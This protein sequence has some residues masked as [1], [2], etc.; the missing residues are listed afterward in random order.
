MKKIAVLSLQ[1]KF[2]Q[3]EANQTVGAAG[4]GPNAMKIFQNR[5]NVTSRLT[6]EGKNM[7]QKLVDFFKE[8][9]G[10]D[11]KLIWSIKAGCSMCPCSPGFNIMTE[12]INVKRRWVLRRG[13]YLYIWAETKKDGTDGLVFRNGVKEKL[14]D[15][16][17]S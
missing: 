15:L 8:T 5:R 13:D 1:S 6:Q 12:D 11:A 16:L 7:K 14:D 17:K 9:Y 10:I 4:V 2:F 3:D